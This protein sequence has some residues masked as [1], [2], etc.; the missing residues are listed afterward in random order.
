MPRPRAQARKICDRQAGSRMLW[1]YA[2]HGNTLVQAIC[3]SWLGW[4]RSRVDD[5]SCSWIA[6]LDVFFPHSKVE[7]GAEK[8]PYMVHRTFA[9]VLGAK[10]RIQ[11]LLTLSRPHVF[12]QYIPNQLNQVPIPNCSIVSNRRRFE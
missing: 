2:Q 11:P 12:Q 6:V 7:D 10:Y 8:G 3:D 9:E 5:A 4:Q 1:K